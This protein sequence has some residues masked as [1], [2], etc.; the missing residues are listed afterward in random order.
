M[1]RVVIIAT[2]LRDVKIISGMG[3]S[4]SATIG[5]NTVRVLA[6]ILQS[7]IAVEEKTIGK[8]SMCPK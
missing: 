4:I 5:A 1:K 6:N 2:I 8:R 3:Y 7:P